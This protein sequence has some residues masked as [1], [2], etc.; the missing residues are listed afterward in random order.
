MKVWITKYALTKGIYELE[1]I[2]DDYCF[3][4][5]NYALFYKGEWETT[6][7]N[8]IRKAEINRNKKVFSLY[9]QIDKLNK[10]KF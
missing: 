2:I 1:G 9:N 6:Q 7:E 5:D 4:P 3:R 10:L 8:A